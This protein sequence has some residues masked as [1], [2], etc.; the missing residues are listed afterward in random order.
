MGLAR[1]VRANL[2]AVRVGDER[3]G[4]GGRAGAGA[5]DGNGGGGGL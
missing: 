2:A 3:A 4:S 1:W 5:G